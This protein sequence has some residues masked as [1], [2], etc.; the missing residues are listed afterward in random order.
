M[1]LRDIANK[2]LKDFNPNEEISN[3]FQALPAGDYRVQLKQVVFAAF[4]KWE[5]LSI[6][7]EVVGG[8]FD[9]RQ[10][11]IRFNFNEKTSKGNDVPEFVLERNAQYVAKVAHLS[12]VTLSDDD[13]E[14]EAH[15]AAAL[16]QGKGSIYMLKIIETKNKKDPDNPYRSYDFE[17]VAGE[18][19]VPDPF[20]T[21]DNNTEISDD[22][23]PFDLD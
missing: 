4:G 13:W 19:N 6:E 9:G 3:G 16:N 2:A 12:G 21:S 18:G 22:K 11:N 14:D 7:Q 8:E 23:L 17:A 1:S 15:L 5:A 10:E 20:A